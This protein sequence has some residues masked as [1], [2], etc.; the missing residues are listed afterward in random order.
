M[1]NTVHKAFEI[2]FLLTRHESLRV[3]ELA[4]HLGIPKSSA[5]NIV[6]T[7]I[8]DGILERNPDTHRV[9]LGTRLIEVGYIA[10]TNLDVVRLATPI[11]RHLNETT[12]ET[13]HLTILDNDEV[14]YVDCVESKKRLRTYSVIGV[15]APLYCTSVGKAIMAYLPSG[16]IDR[17]IEDYGLPRITEHTITDKEALLSDL[18][19]VR[20]RGFAIDNMEHENHLR[21]I[22][23]PVR[24]ARGE[25][26][27]SISISGP[28]ERMP[29]E[30]VDDLGTLVVESAA[31][32]SERMGF[33]AKKALAE[34]SS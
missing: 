28:I 25:V 30:Q 13:V 9:F 10:Q 5:H 4:A 29:T 3:S 8:D 21:C 24:N 18:N 34:Y 15:R 11:I 12:D 2:L 6:M 22:G 33:S 16:E 20:E 17:I 1:V 27:A 26:F 32:L 7:M 19:L 23:A 31:A 14:L